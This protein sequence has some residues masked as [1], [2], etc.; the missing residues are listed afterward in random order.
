MA[1]E[2]KNGEKKGLNRRQFIK[3]AGI[4]VAAAGLTTVAPKLVRPARAADK[5]HVLVGYINPSTGPLA[6]FGAPTPWAD[7]Q[8]LDAINKKGGVY[9]D[10]LGKSVPVKWV[11]LDSQSNPT[12]A[13]ELANR[14][15]MKDKVDILM[16]CHT[17]DTVNP[18]CAVAERTKT[19]C[20]AVDAPFDDWMMGGPYKW[21]FLHFWSVKDGIFPVYTGMW[22]QLS[23]NKMVGGLWPNDPDGTGWSEYFGA[24]APKLGY[25]VVDLGRFPFMQKDFGTHIN[26]FKNK[27]VEIVTGVLIPPDFTTALRQFK[28]MGFA[29]KVIT[30]G[31]AILF[32]SAVEALGSGLGPGLTTEIWWSPHHP[33]S[34]SLTGQSAADLCGLWEKDTAKQWTPPIGFKHSAWELVFDVMNR[35][36]S[37]DKETIR[38]AMADT[39]M[40]SIVGPVKYN[41]DNHSPTPLVGGQWVKGEKWP[42]ELKIVFNK[43]A[44]NI[45]LTGELTPMKW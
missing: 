17:P 5:D 13:A 22:E 40:N 34:S 12:M 35:A 10:S 30:M 20:I 18:A 8:C 45:P 19:P 26:A 23:T 33:F 14:L 4:G 1:F 11:N 16:P 21:S 38:K 31:K 24:N 44:P 2:K 32:P 3:T 41:K 9:I 29:P 6:A 27:K 28:Q 37:F 43:T 15:V 42:F 39:N 7:E 36:K 25:N